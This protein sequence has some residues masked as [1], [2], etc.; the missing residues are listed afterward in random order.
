MR[1]DDGDTIASALA[2]FAMALLA[3]GLIGASLVMGRKMGELF[4]A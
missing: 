2:V 1:P 4:R 3:T